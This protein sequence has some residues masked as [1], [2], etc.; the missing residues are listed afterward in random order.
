MGG[1]GIEGSLSSSRS[2]VLQFCTEIVHISGK[3]VFNDVR[4]D[5]WA[6]IFSFA[7]LKS[8]L[9]PC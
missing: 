3:D 1:S 4:S 5:R 2:F 6:V 8:F 7:L 9:I